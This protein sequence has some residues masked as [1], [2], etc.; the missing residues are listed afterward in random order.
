MTNEKYTMFPMGN[1]QIIK[2][3]DGHLIGNIVPYGDNFIAQKLGTRSSNGRPIGVGVYPS[4][5]TAFENVVKA[6]ERR[7]GRK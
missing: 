1:N 3:I 5:D 4:L 7:P 2:D 6:H